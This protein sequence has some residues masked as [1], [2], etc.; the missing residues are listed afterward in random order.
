M[1]IGTILNH[2][3]ATLPNDSMTSSLPAFMTSRYLFPLT[4]A[5]W[6]S[7]AYW[8]Y[9]THETAAET[10]AIVATLV[11]GLWVWLWEYLLPYRKKW[12]QNDGDFR[13]DVI[14]LIVSG[15]ISKIIK[16]LYILL[17]FPLVGYLGA[18]FGQDNLW[19]HKWP[20][21]LQ[22][23]LILVLCEFCR[24]WVHRW[25][26]KLPWLWR[27]HA[28]HHSPNRLYW[29]NAGRFHPVER[30]YLQFAELLPFILLQP[31][32]EV[33]MLYLITNSIHGFFQHANVQTRVGWLNYVFS[34]T[35]LHRWHHSK[36]ISQ[37]DNNFGNILSC[38][39]LVFG[40][41]YLPEKTEVGSI[42]LMNPGYPKSYIGQLAAPFHA[43][44]DKPDD[45]ENR[46]DYYLEKALTESS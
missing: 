30:A 16:P 28:V 2:G 8:F 26:H 25:S 40:T 45:Y 31:S 17:L 27:F 38:W 35:E 11:G 42:G 15:G 20:I 5:V 3:A 13:T 7:V 21:L 14:H 41:Y 24:Y 10:V 23:C 32:E 18:Q 1:T 43:N 4:L 9:T 46:K 37:S 33:L 29:W 6:L 34:M 36:V 22:L 39:D 19:P 44:R 12:N